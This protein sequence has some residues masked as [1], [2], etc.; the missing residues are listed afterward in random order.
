M[1]HALP[2]LVVGRKRLVTAMPSAARSWSAAFLVGIACLVLASGCARSRAAEVVDGPPLAVPAPPPRL[3]APIEDEPLASA[4]GG[5]ETPLASAPAVVQERVTRPPSPPPASP[6]Q[7]T[8][9]ASTTSPTPPPPAALPEVRVE[10]AVD[11]PALRKEVEEFLAS[12]ERDLKRIS[13]RSLN[14]QGREQLKEVASLM[15]AARKGLNERN[16]TF[17]RQQ[18]SKAATIAASLAR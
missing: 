4:P 8:P 6:R 9:D 15:A 17:A 11:D 2:L 1:R 5:P 18:A 16:F 10:S 14:T 12:A 7:E 13:L 3:I